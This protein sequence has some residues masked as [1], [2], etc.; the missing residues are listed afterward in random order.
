VNWGM[1]DDKADK[2]LKVKI[3]TILQ[4]DKYKSWCF[5]VNSSQLSP[6]IQAQFLLPSHS[7]HLHH[8]RAIVNLSNIRNIFLYLFYKMRGNICIRPTLESARSLTV[9]WYSGSIFV[10]ISLA[11]SSSYTCRIQTSVCWSPWTLSPQQT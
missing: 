11:S 10:A 9:T 8:T 3:S 2:L 6:D 5:S 7:L 4:F 1:S